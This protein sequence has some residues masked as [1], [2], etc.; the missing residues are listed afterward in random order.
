V[1]QGPD[2][3]AQV[4]PVGEK[5]EHQRGCHGYRGRVTPAAER[6]QRQVDKSRRQSLD[7]GDLDRIASRDV[8]GQ[9]RKSATTL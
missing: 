5:S 9:V 7:A 8:L 2:E 1:S 3:Q 4:D 6:R